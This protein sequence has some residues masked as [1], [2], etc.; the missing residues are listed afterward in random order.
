MSSPSLAANRVTVT[1]RDGWDVEL[2]ELPGEPARSLVHLGNF[3]L[4]V[5]RGDYGSGAVEIMG[6]AGIFMA[7]MEFAAPAASTALF[8]GGVMPESLAVADFSGDTL[9]RR[10]PNQL[11]TQQFFVASGRPFVLYAVL[12]STFGAA[13]L[14]SEL[15]RV[16]DGISI[17]APTQ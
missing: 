12:G 3:A 13:M 15:N 10:L 14:V 2:S 16:L 7:L 9:Q 6:S 4:P 11:G 1:V 17:S 5:E 8:R